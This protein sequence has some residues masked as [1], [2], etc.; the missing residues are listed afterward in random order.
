MIDGDKEKRVEM[1]GD[2][3]ALEITQRMNRDRS[4]SVL[5]VELVTRL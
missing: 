1:S 2:E 3:T 4:I 5:D